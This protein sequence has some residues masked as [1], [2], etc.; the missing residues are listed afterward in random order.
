MVQK[1]DTCMVK[2]VLKY[3]G[4]AMWFGPVLGQHLWH[5]SMLAWK[6]CNLS[7]IY[8]GRNLNS[9]NNIAWVK[10]GPWVKVSALQDSEFESYVSQTCV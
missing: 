6:Q 10:V 5:L 8:I 2:A 3:N 1:L 4:H 7:A 9:I